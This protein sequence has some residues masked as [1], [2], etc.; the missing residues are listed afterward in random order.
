MVVTKIDP[1]EMPKKLL[2]GRPLAEETVAI[3]A[4]LPGE[5]IRFPCRWKHS[6]RLCHGYGLALQTAKRAGFR[7]RSVC[8]D[9]VVY[10]M[11]KPGQNEEGAA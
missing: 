11:R 8:R 9:G 7:I 3:Q 1:S 4:L 10:V 2:F 6:D 5:A